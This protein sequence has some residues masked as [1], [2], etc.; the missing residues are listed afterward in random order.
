MP[1]YIGISDKQ[2]I[3][4]QYKYV[5]DIAWHTLFSVLKKKKLS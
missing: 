5:L 2:E 1:N 4:V 3:I